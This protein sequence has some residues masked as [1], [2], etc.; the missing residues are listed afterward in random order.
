MVADI[1][2]GI[3]TVVKIIGCKGIGALPG[4]SA[5]DPANDWLRDLAARPARPHTAYAV[6]SDY[7]PT[8]GV[9]QLVR[10][11]DGLADVVFSFEANDMV[12]PAGGVYDA[13]PATGFPIP[14]ERRIAFGKSESVWHCAY[15]GQ[16]KTQDALLDWLTPA[17]TTGPSPAL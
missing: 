6:G 15:F 7:A 5:M 8:G 1:L 16:R 17:D 9:I 11:A 13:A 4:L 3:L 2:D 10:V 14:P 12:V